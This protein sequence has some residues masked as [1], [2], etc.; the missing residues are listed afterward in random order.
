MVVGT[1]LLLSASLAQ[2]AE[3][4]AKVV[5]KG[6]R[7]IEA[8]GKA[9][10]KG[11]KW[12]NEMTPKAAR[13]DPVITI[14][15]PDKKVY[16][17]ISPRQKYGDEMPIS[18]EQAQNMMKISEEA[19]AKMKNI[20]T[21][22][23]NGYEC[24]KYERNRPSLASPLDSIASLPPSMGKTQHIWIAKKLGVPIK[25]AAKDG[26]FLV[27]YKD[28]KEEKL[29]DS[30]FEPPPGYQINKIPSA[31]LDKMRKELKGKRLK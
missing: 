23:V 8:S 14:M 13:I 24:E 6:D 10:V 20:G 5:T 11:D 7:L 30:L 25:I 18:E 12:R 1:I 3:F 2:A 16:W 17:I 19:K 4:S 29:D 22:T 31:W 15:R 27:E 26:S 28:I 9:Y 21:E